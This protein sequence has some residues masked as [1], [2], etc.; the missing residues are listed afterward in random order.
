MLKYFLKPLD[1]IDIAVIV[2]IILWFL[3]FTFNRYKKLQLPIFLTSHALFYISEIILNRGNFL[4]PSLAVSVVSFI[5]FFIRY[6]KNRKKAEKFSE[7]KW[8][9]CFLSVA[10]ILVFIF[11]CILTEASSV[12]MP[13]PH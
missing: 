4:V 7:I 9:Y 2:L 5:G 1:C 6:I 13:P 12:L 10:L 3:L 8:V 11:G